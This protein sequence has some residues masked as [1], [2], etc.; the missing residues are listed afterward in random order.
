MA[1]WSSADNEI[2][3]G[4]LDIDIT[5]PEGS[6]LQFDCLSVGKISYEFDLIEDVEDAKSI[7]MIMG[8]CSIKVH[9]VASD[10]SSIY[11]LL[12]D[13]SVAYGLSNALVNYTVTLELT[14]PS[15]SVYNF[16]YY[17]TK[18]DVE[19][20][21]LSRTTSIKLRT[22]STTRALVS[23]YFNG[24]VSY[25]NGVAIATGVGA[26]AYDAFEAT[27]SRG[28]K[29]VLAADFVKDILQTV[30]ANYT[31]VLDSEDDTL[32]LSNSISSN[33]T[34]ALI[35][36]DSEKASGASSDLTSLSSNVECFEVVGAMAALE[37]A[38]YGSGF[39]TNFFVNRLSTANNVE[40]S[41]DNVGELK[42]MQSIRQWDEISVNYRN[43]SVSTLNFY[44]PGDKK[45][46]YYMTP[47][48]NSDSVNACYIGNFNGSWFTTT[49]PYITHDVDAA[50]RAYSYSLGAT[51]ES[52]I[53][54]VVFGIDKVKPHQVFSLDSSFSSRY[55]GRTF[56]PTSLEYD[57]EK[58]EIYIEAYQVA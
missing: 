46:S 35:A 20:D 12:S 6:D 45:F 54:L 58:D 41:E 36:D 44:V 26:N 13:D 4:T 57:L 38:I 56:R 49:A 52:K 47:Q 17:F 34:Y 39:N 33:T 9:D 30:N 28:N 29:V 1:T 24:D 15:S 8:D 42:V 18:A 43:A 10:G 23:D 5:Y 16:H 22:F 2:A 48:T 27:V 37:G 21:D 50:S 55:Q 14:T 25:S 19:T 53:E 31:F 7:G 11:A 32:V 40:I 3:S 51:G